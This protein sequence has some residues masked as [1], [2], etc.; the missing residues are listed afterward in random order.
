MP[1]T[2]I[3]KKLI[4]LVLEPLLSLLSTPYLY[5]LPYKPFYNKQCFIIT[6]AQSGQTY[7]QAAHQIH[8]RLRA[9]SFKSCIASRSFA[10]TL[11]PDTPFFIELLRDYPT[12]LLRKF[13]TGYLLHWYVILSLVHLLLRGYPV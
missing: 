4:R 2:Y 12:I 5:P 11:K 3:I 7:T 1:I 8:P 6:S 13:G 10:D 9:V